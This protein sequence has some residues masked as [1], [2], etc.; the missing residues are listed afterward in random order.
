MILQKK[1][2][3]KYIVRIA[4]IAVLVFC[5]QALSDGVIHGTMNDGASMNHF[6]YLKHIWILMTVLIMLVITRMIVRIVDATVQIDDD[7]SILLFLLF[8]VNALIAVIS[9]RIYLRKK[10]TTV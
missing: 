2:I 3:A 1:Q 7:I 10:E 4:K 9:H 6:K 8:I 5:A